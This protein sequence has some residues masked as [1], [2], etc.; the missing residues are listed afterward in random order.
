M[1]VTAVTAGTASAGAAWASA[2]VSRTLSADTRFYVDPGSEAAHQALTDLVNR[3]YVDAVQM[4]KLATWPEA[5]W[6]TKGTPSEVNGQVRDLVHRAAAQRA[7]PVLV[8]Y[9]IPLRD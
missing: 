2:P 9:D 1:G 5:A 8:A 6:F 3:D 7:V 4:A